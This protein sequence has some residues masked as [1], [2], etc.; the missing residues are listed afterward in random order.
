MEGP[1]K[2]EKSEQD[3]EQDLIEIFKDFGKDNNTTE[4]GGVRELIEKMPALE[5]ILKSPE[6]I[7]SAE[8]FI[9]KL[10]DQKE[11]Q[12]RL[13]KIISETLKEK[14]KKTLLMFIKTPMNPGLVLSPENETLTEDLVLEDISI[15]KKNSCLREIEEGLMSH[16][17]TWLWN[18]IKDVKAENTI[19]KELEGEGKTKEEALQQVLESLLEDI[20][21]TE[22]GF[23]IPS[24]NQNSERFINIQSQKGFHIKSLKILSIDK[25]DDNV[26]V[27][28]EIEKFI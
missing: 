15:S 10:T 2:N 11:I 26:I 22:Y 18:K 6:Y 23:S 3:L 7:D 16:S 24:T 20:N 25:K 1:N 12:E 14:N 9:E 21:G 5:E 17:E 4:G 13:K 27:S 19:K 28:V 8:G